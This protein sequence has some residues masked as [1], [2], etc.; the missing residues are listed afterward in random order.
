VCY[1]EDVS[2]GTKVLSEET[3][4]V[5]VSMLKNKL[6]SGGNNPLLYAYGK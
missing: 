5:D 6:I 4:L 1:L 3:D 2:L